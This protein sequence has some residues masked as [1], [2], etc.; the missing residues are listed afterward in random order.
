M[1]DNKYKIGDLVLDTTSEVFGIIVRVR[2]QGIS[3]R[4]D[5]GDKWGYY[6]RWQ[7]TGGHVP[8]SF[9]YEYEISQHPDKNVLCVAHLPF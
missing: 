2:L 9:E 4:R 3:Q 7:R 6:V 5:N 8:E 1:R